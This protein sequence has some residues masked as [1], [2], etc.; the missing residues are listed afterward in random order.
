V[1]LDG[2][3]RAAYAEYRFQDVI[4]PVSEF[5][6]NELSALYFDIRKDSLYCD[7]PD[8]IRRRA[9]RTVLDAVFERLT[10]WLSPITPFTMEEAWSTRFPTPASTAPA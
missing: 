9:C 7:R 10:A 6:S 3:V 4:R 1:E 5:C 8:A 2:Q